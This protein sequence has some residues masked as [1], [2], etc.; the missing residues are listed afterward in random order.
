[1][2]GTS[3]GGLTSASGE[4]LERVIYRSRSTTGDPL[5]D[6]EDILKVSVWNNARS[7]ITGVLGHFGDCYLQLLEG[8]APALDNLLQQLRVDPR[9]TELM[10]LDRRELPARLF[11]GWSMARTDIFGTHA[12]TA[13]GVND[14]TGLALRLL[15][16]F[17]RDET[18]VV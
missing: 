4:T 7:G 9:H 15:D 6:M 8:T 5:S 16:L 2:T 13:S 3:P 14:A 18:V 11:P 12:P 1:M 17:R 10:I